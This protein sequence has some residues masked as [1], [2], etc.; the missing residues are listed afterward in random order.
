MASWLE[1]LPAPETEGGTDDEGESIDDCRVSCEGPPS[2]GEGEGVACDAATWLQD[3]G[4]DS[5]SVRSALDRCN[6]DAD[7]ALDLLRKE[8]YKPDEC[9][10]MESSALKRRRKDDE[11]CM[12]FDGFLCRAQG[13]RLVLRLT[14]SGLDGP[15]VGR[16]RAD[17]SIFF[18]GVNEWD[19]EIY[20]SDRP[21]KMPERLGP[22]FD[23]SAASKALSRGE[24]FIWQDFATMEEVKVA[25]AAME[26]MASDGGFSAAD[27]ETTAA[28]KARTDRVTFLHARGNGSPK[29]PPPCL[30]LV[31]RLEAAAAMLDWPDGDE[32]LMPRMGMA[33][34]YDAKGSLYEIHRD[35]E[36]QPNGKW[37]NHRALTAIAYV[38]PRGFESEHDGGVLR[39]HIGTRITDR[40]GVTATRTEDIL[41]RG[42]IAVLF[43]SRQLMHEVL[44]SHARRYAL[45][46]WLLSAPSAGR[47]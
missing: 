21:R 17:G 16:I 24:P 45:T 12:E 31:Q 28:V 4:F 14:E 44:P 42:G 18:R 32:L 3:A 36:K 9:C 15:D 22:N 39:C 19:Q 1:S 38:N 35:N 29:F 27:A 10:E 33:S 2:S 8:M 47:N 34:I 40:T 20:W 37:V 43:P 46:L 41:P 13:N 5:E 6:G 23:V 7:E 26:M 30:A 11:E 25:H